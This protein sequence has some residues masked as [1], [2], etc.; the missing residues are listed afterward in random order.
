MATVVSQVGLGHGARSPGEHQQHEKPDVT[1]ERLPAEEERSRAEGQTR[2]RPSA[3]LIA[4]RSSKDTHGPRNRA[5]ESD[6]TRLSA[7][8]SWDVAKFRSNIFSGVKLV[9]VS[10]LNR[11]V[12]RRYGCFF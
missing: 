7:S 5:N 12:T 4:L 11:R 9:R 3:N 10:E 8:P 1:M 2:C 6:R